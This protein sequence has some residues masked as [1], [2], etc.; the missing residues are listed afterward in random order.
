M[1]LLTI[2]DNLRLECL[3]DWK[4][5]GKHYVIARQMAPRGNSDEGIRLANC[6]VSNVFY[7]N[8]FFLVVCVCVGGVYVC[9]YVYV[10]VCVCR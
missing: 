5:E 4:H 10:Y 9:G 1:F 2:A 8:N 3:S 6:F 7:E